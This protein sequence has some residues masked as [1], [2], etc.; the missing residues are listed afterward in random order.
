MK[1]RA[2]LACVLF[3][4]GISMPME[5]QMVTGTVLGAV[6]D[7]SGTR[8]AQAS[9]TIKNELTG[10]TR[11]TAANE[12]GDYIV[13]LLPVGRYQIDVEAP[14]FKR[15]S[16]RGIQLEVNQNARVDVRL[17]IGQVNQEVVV[18]ADATLVDTR[19]VQVGGLVDSRRVID[20]PLNGRNVYSLVQL[21]PGVSGVSLQPQ[22]D[23]TIG[24]VLNANGGRQLQNTFMLDGGFNNAVNRN[25]GLSAP[26]PDAVEEFRLITS[27]FNAEYGRS[28]GAVV[29]V[30]TRSGTNSLHGSLYEYLRNDALDARSFFQPSVA[31]LRQ[32]QFGGSVG[33][34]V[35]RNK[36]FFF[37][38]YQGDRIGSGQF[39]NGARTPTAAQRRGD[40]SNLARLTDP[41]LGQPFPGRL[42]PASRLD[43]VAQ[44]MLNFIPLPNT[45]DGR[46][47]ASRN[48]SANSDQ[49]FGKIDYQASTAHRLSV[50][51]FFVRANDYYPFTNQ[52]IISNIPDFAPSTATPHQSNVT[53][54]ETWTI[55]PR[56][57]N[58]LTFGYTTALANLSATTHT[59]WPEYGSNFTPATL[60]A[61]AP[62]I[63]VSGA[64]VGGYQGDRTDVE[65]VVSFSD[66]VT[67]VRGAHSVKTGGSLT[68][69]NFNYLGLVRNAG[70]LTVSGGFSGNSTA[71]FMLGRAA[72]LQVSNGQD[73][74][75]KSRNWAGF[76]QDDWKVSRRITL[77]LGLRYE[78]FTPFY[79]TQNRLV[80][81]SPGQQSKILPN[82]P[83]SL[84]YPGDTGV[85]RGLG[86]TD[87]NDLAP[88]FGVAVDVFGNGKTA[89]R[90]G[91]G[92]FYSTGF[93]GLTFSSQGQPFQ[94]D[95]TAFGTPSFVNPFGNAGGNPFPIPAG[96][97][98]FVLPASVAWK[99][100][101]RTPYVQ[102]YS[103]TIQQQLRRD[104]SLEATYLG[105]TSR[106]LQQARDGNQP[107]YIPGR[108]TAANVN[109]RRPIQPGTFG[110]IAD[111]QTAGNAS[112]NSLQTTLNRRFSHGFTLLANY[113]YS[114][115]IDTQSE[116]QQSLANIN[117]ADCNNTQLDRG[118]SN[119]DR[120]HVFNLSFVWQLPAV[121]HRGF[122][123]RH[124]LGGWQLNAIARYASGP[125]LN[126]TSGRD[127]NLNGI[128]TDRP[129]LV[130]DPHLDTGRSK[131]QRL[132]KYFDP[133]A[134]Q[135]AATGANGTA[136]RNILYGPGT[137]NWD[138]SFFRAFPVHERHQL[139]FRAEFFNIFNKARFSNPVANLSNANA[140][141]ILGAGPGRVAQLGMRYS[142]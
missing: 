5:A 123:G 121:A 133:R 111:Q 48:S 140:G 137:V 138:M 68:F 38:S 94:I 4:M 41:D 84:V 18:T 69:L 16:R 70:I 46:V 88:R 116:D 65:P 54:N 81:F 126:V 122:I 37:F 42:I 43:P 12:V 77:N 23:T 6:T 64:W 10:D 98:R 74:Y 79:D 105:N 50:G 25:G 8:V 11:T 104:L 120:R 141:T 47:E 73:I 134:F 83:L 97:A 66:A 1:L 108:S 128:N 31:K 139:Q 89:I 96:S 60:P 118:V 114:K 90:A 30:I 101:Q 107:V 13:P 17:E 20:L 26:N 72:S 19:Q 87:F 45:P 112:Y 40:F 7:P 28:A 9:I 130:G 135:F 35:V 82:A 80:Q 100:Q 109:D 33:G 131:D 57:L 55:A 34:P 103:F 21:L 132:A 39:V 117:F 61:F 27:N 115:A 113:T 67:W 49:Y 75:M 110:L 124:V 29:N 93:S 52:S 58:Q 22:P 92:V 125:A 63:N 32:N 53:A 95:V 14:G 127:S 136:G 15:S 24:N 2:L 56:L 76:F 142:F 102:Q 51:L 86:P 91:Y 36:V 119:H 99:N 44:K 85:P 62:Q 71:D 78:V 3:V 59:S 106:K 129:D